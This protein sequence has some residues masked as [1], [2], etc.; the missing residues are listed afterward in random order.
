MVVMTLGASEGV[1]GMM[2]KAP[3]LRKLPPAMLQRVPRSSVNAGFVAEGTREA[4]TPYV[5]AL[6]GGETELEGATF[7]ITNRLA[8]DVP[9]CRWVAM[10]APSS[11]EIYPPPLLPAI[12]AAVRVAPVI[13]QRSAA[14]DDIPD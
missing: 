6:N 12:S 5:G 2:G 9:F 8:S 7:P 14:T 4:G 11:V 13:V 3:V 1:N 10:Y